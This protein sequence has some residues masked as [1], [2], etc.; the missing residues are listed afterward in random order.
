MK[1]T[2]VLFLSVAT[3]VACL[4]LPV[5]AVNT[6]DVWSRTMQSQYDGAY[7]VDRGQAGIYNHLENGYKTSVTVALK[8]GVTWYGSKTSYCYEKTAYTLY[9]YW[10]DHAYNCTGVL[11]GAY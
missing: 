3:I 1:K 8:K 7:R 9:S 11:V 6:V 10:V 5:F 4:S 2:L